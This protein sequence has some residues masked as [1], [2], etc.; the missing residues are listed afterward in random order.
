MIYVKEF[1]RGK[2]K[3]LIFSD[4]KYLQG[5]LKNTKRG[6]KWYIYDTEEHF[7][8][9]EPDQ[10]IFNITIIRSNKTDDRHRRL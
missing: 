6:F 9:D 3:L 5:Y 4:N 7:L 10:I 2:E 8:L 1:R